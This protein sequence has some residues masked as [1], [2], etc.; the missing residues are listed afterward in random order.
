M[1]TAFVLFKCQP[2]KELGVYLALLEI[3]NVT[4]THVA[5]GEY[6]LVARVDFE[7]EVQMANTLIGKMRAIP[8]VQKTETLIAVEA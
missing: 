7:D 4:E 8:G 2:Q 5:Y 3:D 6:D 1:S